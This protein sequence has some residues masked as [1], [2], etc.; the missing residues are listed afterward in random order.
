MEL[1]PLAREKL[2]RIGNLSET[3]KQDLKYSEKLTALLSNY[4]TDRIDTNGLWTEMKGFKEAGKESMIKETQN[5][6]LYAITLG[7]SDVD[8]DRCRNGILSAETLKPDGRYSEL[9]LSLNAI[10]K[11][12]GQ[13][14]QDKDAAFDSMKAQIQDQV[15]R[16]AQQAQ[17]Q[18]GKEGMAIDIQGSIE[19]SLKS[20]PQW[21]NFIVKHE[22]NYGQKFDQQIKNIESL[23]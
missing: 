2:S 4:F 8:F 16:A 13:Y 21:R 19:A 1:S 11:L 12:R 5:R 20:S 23:L 7:G 10:E 6:L 15:I 3:E 22:K 17:R 18:A 9:E 14:N